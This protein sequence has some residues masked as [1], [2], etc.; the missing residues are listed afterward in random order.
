MLSDRDPSVTAH[1]LG[2]STWF[3]FGS[4]TCR[5]LMGF[6]KH[7][8]ENNSA[9]AGTQATSKA[10]P[11]CCELCSRCCRSQRRCL[12]LPTSVR[13][14]STICSEMEP[15]APGTPRGGAHK[16][17]LFRSG[18]RNSPFLRCLTNMQRSGREKTKKS[19]QVKWAKR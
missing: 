3:D 8:M 18:A 5:S 6:G 12:G 13:T 4:P 9:A 14:R 1:R 11:G 15:Q 7:P 19:S 2:S 17:G 10:D 16:P